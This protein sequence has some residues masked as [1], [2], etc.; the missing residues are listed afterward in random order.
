MTNLEIFL[1]TYKKHLILNREKHPDIYAWPENLLD[2]VFNR[3]KAAIIDGT[4]NK[5]SQTFKDTCKE[6]KI[7]HTYKDISRYISE[8]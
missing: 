3:M 2:T 1:D 7:K 8:L 4:F 5:D 6:L